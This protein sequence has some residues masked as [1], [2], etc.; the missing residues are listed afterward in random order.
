MAKI[1]LEI[2]HIFRRNFGTKRPKLQNRPKFASHVGLL[3]NYVSATNPKNFFRSIKSTSFPDYFSEKI[4]SID[5]IPA[6]LQ[7]FKHAISMFTT[8]QSGIW[9]GLLLT[10][11]RE[12]GW[13]TQET[14]DWASNAVKTF[15]RYLRFTFYQNWTRF[16]SERTVSSSNS[17]SSYNLDGCD[18]CIFFP[19]RNASRQSSTP[20]CIFI[21]DRDRQFAGPFGLSQYK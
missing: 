9:V 5:K 17:M 1:P 16:L 15:L 3:Y 18:V 19:F 4:I 21:F 7:A 10:S 12:P 2:L 11:L 6:F 8:A 13:N 14:F 20:R